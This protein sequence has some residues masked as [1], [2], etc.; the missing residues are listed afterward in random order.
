MTYKVIPQVDF[1]R[2]VQKLLSLG[3]A[4]SP[5]E[6]IVLSLWKASVDL[7]MDFR[8]L[9]DQS[10]ANGKL[11]VSQAV[12]DRLNR[13]VPRN[14][15]YKKKVPIKSGPIFRRELRYNEY[16]YITEDEVPL[17]SESEQPLLKE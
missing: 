3:L 12:L 13:N 5:A 7:N 10:T 14:V 2:A 16:Q 6:N 8:K 15:R 1:D 9:I 17:I 11:D 4:R